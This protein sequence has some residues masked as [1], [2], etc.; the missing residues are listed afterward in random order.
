MTGS[1]DSLGIQFE[2]TLSLSWSALAPMTLANSE[3]QQQGNIAL[4]RALSSIETAIPEPELH[5]ETT[6][7]TLERIEAKLDIVFLLLAQLAGNQVQL[8]R[9]KKLA[10]AATQ[11][12]W[13]EPDKVPATGQEI[14]V[15]IYLNPRLPQA[16]KLVALVIELHEKEGETL[17]TAT[18][19]NAGEE[20]T[21]WLTRTI[22]RYHR[23]ALQARKQ[24]V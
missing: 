5:A 23:R 6:Q 15:E 10:L 14:Q 24:S 2:A 22:F 8:P 17:V 18:L 3:L 13:A 11:I 4:L 1:N 19:Q 7:K 16:L 20:L 21:E 12:T 9:E